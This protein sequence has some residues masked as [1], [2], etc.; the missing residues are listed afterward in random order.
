[1][2]KLQYRLVVTVS[3][4]L[5]SI[6]SAAQST[7]L[8]KEES[9]QLLTRLNSD[10]PVKFNKKLVDELVKLQDQRQKLFKEAVNTDS[11]EK[12]VQRMTE[13]N[14]KAESRLCQVLKEFGWPTKKLVGEDGVEAAV[15]ILKSSA[16]LRLQIDLFPVVVAAVKKGDLAK[17]EFADYF[18][19]VRVRAGLKQIF[20]TQ[21]VLKNGILILEP[22]EEEAHVDDRRKQYELPPLADY[23]KYLEASYQVPV[24]KSPATSRAQPATSSES[25]AAS[26][27]SSEAAGIP[28]G[29]VDEVIRI[30]TQLVNLNVGVFSNTLNSYVS[31]LAKED[32]VVLEDGN[33]QAITFFEATNEPFD[34]VLLIDLSGSTSGKRELIRKST[35]RFI[36]AA[37]PNDRMAIVTFSDT[38]NVVSPL[39]DNRTKLLESVGQ[40]KGEG[41]SHIWDA[42]KYCMDEVVGPKSLSRRRAI[43]LM[44]D[45]VDNAL[46][47]LG[48]GSQI[49]FADLVE[50]VRRSDTLIIPIYLET[51]D[52]DPFSKRMS[53]HAR[54]TLTL[55]ASE[56]GALYYKARKIEDLNGV[57]EQVINDLGKVYSLGYRPT[58]STSDG[59]WR[60]VKIQVLN[61]PE[62]VTRSR[63]GYYAN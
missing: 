34:L 60:S 9:N 8:T 32:F 47:F 6:P 25:S 31:S 14:E 26:H 3:V 13:F 62:M 44:S 16:R 49:S 10:E 37:R 59:G 52:D 54:N 50:A 27:L 55:L 24:V 61:H 33:P 19:R 30:S 48:S 41:G 45:G 23:L 20:G 38:V 5:C 17:A 2:I 46:F 12:S 63:P 58:N 15:F 56:S 7:C 11:K 53:R 35:Q 1:M 4:L 22:I 43:V 21:A 39:T 36:E 57:Y 29:S 28:G 42:V 51:G 40:M 18:D